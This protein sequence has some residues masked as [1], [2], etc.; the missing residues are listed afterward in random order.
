MMPKISTFAPRLVSLLVAAL[1]LV[2]AG[3]ASPNNGASNDATPNQGDPRL[4]PLRRVIFTGKAAVDLVDLCGRLEGARNIVWRLSEGQLNDVEVALALALDKDLGLPS[5]HTAYNYYRQIALA[6]WHQHHLVYFQG[7][8]ESYVE[9]D[10]A[11]RWMREPLGVS[12]GG[13]SVWCAIYDLQGKTFVKFK[14]E[15]SGTTTS[16]S[17]HGVA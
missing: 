9:G 11:R 13:T 3:S 4:N 12:D 7:F 10:A 8:D 2:L 16:I 6:D 17:F 1:A 14:V 15:G 5:G